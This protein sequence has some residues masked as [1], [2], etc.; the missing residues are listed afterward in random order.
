MAIGATIYRKR[1]REACPEKSLDLRVPQLFC[2]VGSFWPA[3]RAKS[4]ASGDLFSGLAGGGALTELRAL[5]RQQVWSRAEKLGT[6]AFRRGAAG[7]TLGAE[8]PFAQPLLA[9]QWRS[10]AYRLSR[11]WR[12]GETQAVADILIGASGIES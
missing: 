2:Q 4:E 1:I 11:D 12:R 6:H 10:S 8:G 5:A 7:A 9:G 3:T